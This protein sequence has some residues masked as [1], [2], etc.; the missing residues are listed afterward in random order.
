MCTYV[1]KNAQ[2]DDEIHDVDGGHISISIHV[3]HHSNT[4]AGSIL[5]YVDTYMIA[6]QHTYMNK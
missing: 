4:N 3:Q 5:D 1:C 6:Q 2:H